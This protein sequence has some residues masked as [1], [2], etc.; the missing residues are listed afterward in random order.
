MFCFWNGC[1]FSQT[2]QPVPEREISIFSDFWL[3]RVSVA[4]ADDWEHCLIFIERRR[5]RLI[6]GWV[7]QVPTLAMPLIRAW[8]PHCSHAWKVASPRFFFVFMVSSASVTHLSLSSR[9]EKLLFIATLRASCVSARWS[10]TPSPSGTSYKPDVQNDILEIFKSASCLNWAVCH[11]VLDFLLQR[12]G[13]FLARHCY[14]WVVWSKA[15]WA[16]VLVECFT[17][18]H[19]CVAGRVADSEVKYP[20]P[21]FPKFPTPTP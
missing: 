18:S 9:L 11:W 20:T 3:D 12:K 1:F 17:K 14:D 7:H 8:S 13:S 21:T 4:P 2:T 16:L 19:N 5:W 10:W 15:A 6:P